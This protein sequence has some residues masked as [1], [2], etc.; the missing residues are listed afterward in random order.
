MSLGFRS[1]IRKY[2]IYGIV[3]DITET[4]FVGKTH[5]KRP[6][7]QY[8]SHMREEHTLTKDTYSIAYL[9]EP[10]FVILECV[11]CTGRMAFKHVLAWYNFFEEHGYA[12]LT[13]EKVGAM[14]GSMS[15]ETQ[16][17]YDAVCAPYTLQEVLTRGVKEPQPEQEEMQ[18]NEREETE[19]LVQMNIRVK[20]SVKQSFRNFCKERD[21]TQSEG[22]RLLLL[23]EDF[24]ERDVVMQAHQKELGVLKEENSLL[25]KQNK[26]LLGFKRGEESWVL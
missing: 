4:V 23:G 16:K 26:E 14:V 1:D 12:I 24:A 7:D 25:K 13:D 8:F 5:S 21:L 19:E 15:Y 9:T 10:D 2:W 3:D 18:E 6:K 20:E 17:I 11:Y 22:L